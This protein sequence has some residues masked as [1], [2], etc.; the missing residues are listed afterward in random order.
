MKIKKLNKTKLHNFSPKVSSGQPAKYP[1]D[2]MK[3]GDS[4]LI[5]H[6]ITL[7]AVVTGY[8]NWRTRRNLKQR[9]FTHRVVKNGIRV[10]RT[11]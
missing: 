10:W 1:Y 9:K 6:K 4:F 3:V 8:G 5:T 7:G 11:K 2:S